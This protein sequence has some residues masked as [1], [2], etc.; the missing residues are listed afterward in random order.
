[1]AV[2]SLCARIVPSTSNCLLV[3]ATPQ[4]PKESDGDFVK[5]VMD[6]LPTPLGIDI[7]VESFDEAASQTCTSIFVPTGDDDLDFTQLGN[8]GCA[9][10]DAV[11]AD[12]TTQQQL[13][14]TV[15]AQK[16]SN[17]LNKFTPGK[18]NT[19]QSAAQPTATNPTGVT[20][21]PRETVYCGNGKILTESAWGHRL[22]CTGED[23]TIAPLLIQ[24]GYLDQAYSQYLLNTLTPGCTFVDV[25]AGIGVY[26]VLAAT[27]VEDSGQVYAYEPNP[28]CFEL[29]TANA[30]LSLT[31]ETIQ[32]HQTAVGAHNTTTELTCSD[33]YLNNG[34]CMPEAGANLKTVA[35]ESCSSH[36]VDMSSLA[37][38]LGGTAHIDFI[39]IS[40]EGY[41]EQVFDG[42]EKL[43][44]RN[45]VGQV[46]FQIHTGKL[47]PD[48]S[49]LVER[50]CRY[51]RQGWRF[52]VALE[53]GEFHEI[54]ISRI[55][56]IDWV[57]RVIMR[58]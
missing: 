56:S 51:D 55:A 26:S 39:D 2:M 8:L 10:I 48:H 35:A 23:T 58:R 53:D 30:E 7:S 17:I 13:S 34:T 6:S 22:Y 49:K 19:N 31:G 9:M 25:G 21:K 52:G 50:L 24:N 27:L 43:V 32:C 18:P 46:A 36:T 40:V 11:T 15:T 44:E 57:P 1:M 29:L 12:E 37:E 41:E 14:Q 20:I 28:T 54:D 16:I 4:E 3:F 5:A 38:L 42:L 47:G 33:K 45:G